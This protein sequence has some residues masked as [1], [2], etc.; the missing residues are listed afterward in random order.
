[1]S[2]KLRSQFFSV[3]YKKHFS[4]FSI[5]QQALLPKILNFQGAILSLEFSANIVSF[6]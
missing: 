6:C 1:M 5:V 3:G 2:F 4:Q